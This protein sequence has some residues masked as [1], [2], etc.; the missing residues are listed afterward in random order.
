M[1]K[2]LQNY[3]FPQS[4]AVRSNPIES[5]IRSLSLAF[6]IADELAKCTDDSMSAD[7]FMQNKL[8]IM[9]EEALEPAYNPALHG[10]EGDNTPYYWL[11]PINDRATLHSFLAF[12]DN[13]T[14]IQPSGITLNQVWEIGRDRGSRTIKIAPA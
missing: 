7:E 13:V 14:R 3:F 12:K 1:L 8:D 4:A 10:D 6:K 11:D 5:R 2:S 9:A